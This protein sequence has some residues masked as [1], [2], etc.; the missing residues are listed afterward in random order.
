MISFLF[1]FEFGASHEEVV[2]QGTSN[3]RKNAGAVSII[4]IL[5][6]NFGFGPLLYLSHTFH[7]YNPMD[8]CTV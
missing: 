1:W 8:L 4:N 2:R 7:K 6:N 3:G 5:F